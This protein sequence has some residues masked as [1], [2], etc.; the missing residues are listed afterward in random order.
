[1]PVIPDA[2][3]V[4]DSSGRIVSANG[5]AEALFGYES[6]SLVGTPVE[7]LV[8]E[9][10]RGRH[11]R[12]R[13]GFMAAPQV[14][15]MGVGLQLTGRRF[16]SSQ[17]PVDISLAPI[18]SEGEQLVVAAIRD[19]SAQRQAAAAQAALRRV[20]TLVA[21]GVPPEEVFATVTAEVGRLMDVDLV[22]MDRYDPD[23]K[24]TVL[25]AQ[26]ATL[27]SGWNIGGRNVSTLVFESG[28]PARIDDYSEA[29]GPGAV[30]TREWGVRSAVGAPIIIEGRL[31]GVMFIASRRAWALPADTESR[32]AD[33]TE[34][35][36][37][38]IANAEAQTALTDSRARIVAAADAARRRIGR[39]LHDGAQQ[40]L[41]SLTLQLRAA[42]AAAPPEA[43]E[44]RA[45]LDRVADGLTS[46]LN[47]LVEFARGIH[48]AILTEGGL[49]PALQMLAGRS[50]IP[51]DLDVRIPGRLPEPLEVCTYYLVSEALANAA[52]HSQAS[53]IAVEV[54]A[55]DDML[56][57]VI[58]DNGVGG[59]SFGTGSGLVGLKDRVET[60][61]G[62]FALQSKPGH[63]TTI[64][65]ELQLASNRVA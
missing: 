22:S 16:D 36:A 24:V 2:A 10:I 56:L 54:T 7:A 5:Q 4:V 58:R 46:V 29:S 62:R 31:W 23:G 27:T 60:L 33:F 65:A 14:R 8:P 41:V 34:L 42:Q 11:R 45:L 63:G 17:F 47:E 49:G 59:A 3:V 32:L 6:G 13:R 43:A 30:P 61:G 44:L 26:P 52:K 15:P 48:P 35:V 1:M 53:A 64:S 12:H 21:R 55:D 25:G 37:M 40:R 28:R 9:R 50:P 20:A 51:V 57:V 39:D 18:V 38:A 19:V